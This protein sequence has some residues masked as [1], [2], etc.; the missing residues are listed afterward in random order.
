[1]ANNFYWSG[2]TLMAK[3]LGEDV[4]L[5]DVDWSEL[6]D[7]EAEHK[8]MLAAGPDLYEAL[9][10]VVS[11]CGPRS[12]DGAIARAALAKARGESQ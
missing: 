9:A 11:R 6:D 7:F 8:A 10:L 1:M 12:E 5:C 4:E 2:E 3:D